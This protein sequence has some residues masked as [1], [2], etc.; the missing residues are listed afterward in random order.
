[1]QQLDTSYSNGHTKLD[2]SKRKNAKKDLDLYLEDSDDDT[3]F[4][5]KK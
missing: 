4:N 3:P 1:M 2:T 5:R